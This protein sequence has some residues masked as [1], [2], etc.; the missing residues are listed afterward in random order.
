MVRKGCGELQLEINS[1]IR[2]YFHDP[3][4]VPELFECSKMKNRDSRFEGVISFVCRELPLGTT[5]LS[6]SFESTVNQAVTIPR[7]MRI[8]F[9]S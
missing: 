7:L 4:K 2:C 5:Q 8:K 9:G 6:S 1:N 3:N